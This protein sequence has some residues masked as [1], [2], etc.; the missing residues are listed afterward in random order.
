[1]LYLSHGD[2]VAMTIV[3]PIGGTSWSERPRHRVALLPPHLP[4]MGSWFRLASIP[5][6]VIP[7]LGRWSIAGT[8]CE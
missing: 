5:S 2:L 6:P 4:A 3:S 7:I 8:Q 1:M